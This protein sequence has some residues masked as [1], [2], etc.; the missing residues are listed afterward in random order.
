MTRPQILRA[1]GA[2]M[3]P[4]ALAVAAA[5]A[6]DAPAAHPAAADAAAAASRPGAGDVSIARRRLN[7]VAGRRALVAGRRALVSGRVARAGAGRAVALQRRGGTG[8][9]T[10]DRDT[11]PPTAA[12]PSA[13]ARGSRAA[14][15]FA[16][17]PERP[18]RAP[19]A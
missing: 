5:L 14:P 6:A 16:C 15:R 12:S 1:A 11:T 9:R 3:A 13:S 8:W 17:A 2:G 19:G 10:I 4:G 7:V 18:A